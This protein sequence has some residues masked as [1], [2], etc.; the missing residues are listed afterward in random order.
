LSQAANRARIFLMIR[1]SRLASKRFKCAVGGRNVSVLSSHLVTVE[2]HLKHL[3]AIENHLQFLKAA[4]SRLENLET[5][6]TNLKS[7]ETI[8]TTLKSLETIGTNLKSLETIGTSLENLE[9]IG[10][11]L[12]SLETIGA[13]LKSLETIGRNL[14]SLETSAQGIELHINSLVTVMSHLK[15]LET[16]EKYLQLTRLTSLKSARTDKKKAKNRWEYVQL[17]VFLLVLCLSLYGLFLKCWTKSSTEEFGSVEEYEKFVKETLK[18]PSHL[19]IMGW[20]PGVRNSSCWKPIFFDMYKQWLSF[21]SCW[22]TPEIISISFQ[23]S[24]HSIPK[25]LEFCTER[26]V[27][28][29]ELKRSANHYKELGF[30][31]VTYMKLWKLTPRDTSFYDTLEQFISKSQQNVPDPEVFDTHLK[32]IFDWTDTRYLKARIQELQKELESDDD[33]QTTLTNS[34]KLIVRYRLKWRFFLD[35]SFFPLVIGAL[36]GFLLK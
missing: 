34:Y 28:E 23:A 27:D 14:K 7:L 25:V 24:E 33:K 20:M 35:D 8:G 12:K 11:N 30:D 22:L 29:E 31:E 26:K 1:Y 21:R 36:L 4:E 13:N 16:I 5:I 3:E 9:T 15:H 10:T 2:S 18:L 6:G 17:L 19:D 32:E